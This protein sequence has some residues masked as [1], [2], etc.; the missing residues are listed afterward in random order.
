MRVRAMSLLTASILVAMGC[1]KKHTYAI[2]EGEAVTLIDFGFDSIPSLTAQAI[3]DFIEIVDSSGKCCRGLFMRE[4]E[5]I[6]LDGKKRIVDPLSVIE[7]GRTYK[8]HGFPMASATVPEKYK[9]TVHRQANITG[10]FRLAAPSDSTEYFDIHRIEQLSDTP[11][12]RLPDQIYI[13]DD[14]L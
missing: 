10:N 3:D 1:Q 9:Q 14:T 13:I 4:I 7:N 12:Y 5:Y 11:L 2:I 8:Y 6:A